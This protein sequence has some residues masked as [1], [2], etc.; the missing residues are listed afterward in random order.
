[1]VITSSHTRLFR[2]FAPKKCVIR[3]QYLSSQL[4]VG[5]EALARAFPLLATS[6]ASRMEEGKERGGAG[7][8]GV[9][10]GLWAESHQD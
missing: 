3:P 2:C 5:Y 7:Q 1:M 9:G 8:P 4:S 10:T 6:L